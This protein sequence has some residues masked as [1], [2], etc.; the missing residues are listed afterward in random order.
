MTS[1]QIG[2]D[3][4]KWAIIGGK[5]GWIH[6]PGDPPKSG[7]AVAQ[8]LLHVYNQY[9]LRF[10]EMYMRSAHRPKA[11][12]NPVM[13]GNVPGVV[14]AP[15]GTAQQSEGSMPMHFNLAN[16]PAQL[17]QLVQYSQLP[18]EVLRT[19]GV[20]QDVIDAVEM[21]RDLLTRIVNGQNQF[22]EGVKSNNNLAAAVLQQRQNFMAS[23][24]GQNA[25]AQQMMHSQAQGNS[26]AQQMQ[27]NN[28]NAMTRP[29]A[30]LPGQPMAPMHNVAPHT[31]PGNVLPQNR[32]PRP[33]QEDMH[34]A[35]LNA[36]KWLFEARTN[37]SKS[38]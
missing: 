13:N 37:Q 8:R 36:S 20:S 14:S 28:A 6:F 25:L 38:M 29:Q 30:A 15:P 16:D 5:L 34:R 18:V 35:Q 33:T 21:N 22:H 9:L 23:Q 17:Q 19:R 4:D 10:D 7:P 24:A 31:A 27:Q 26:M 32:I 3:L 11:N 1:P 2:T 12:A